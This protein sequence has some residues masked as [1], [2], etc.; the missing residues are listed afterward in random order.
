VWEALSIPHIL[1]I[2]FNSSALIHNKPIR[3]QQSGYQITCSLCALCTNS[4]CIVRLTTTRHTLEKPVSLKVLVWSRRRL[5][6]L[7]ILLGLTSPLSEELVLLGVLPFLWWRRLTA[8]R[9]NVSHFAYL[10]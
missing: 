10:M 8:L 3:L 1:K 6:T 7:Q 4:V 9:A 5:V 2:I